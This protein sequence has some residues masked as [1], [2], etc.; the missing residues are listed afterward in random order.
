MT[1]SFDSLSNRTRRYFSDASMRRGE[2]Y[3]EE[4][5]V[6]LQRV[7]PDGVKA[8]V[9]GSGDASYEL[10][11]RWDRVD[12]G[13]LGVHCTCPFFQRETE[14][15]KHLWA[16]IQV[17]D[18]EGLHRLAPGNEPLELLNRSP[19]GGHGG[20]AGRRS[21]YYAPAPAPWHQ[22]LH[23]LQQS[24]AAAN[25]GEPVLRSVYYLINPDQDFAKTGTL[26]LTFFR[27]NVLAGGGYGKL[28]RGHLEAD[29]VPFLEPE[30][31]RL[32]EILFGLATGDWQGVVSGSYGSRTRRRSVAIDP[33]L[34]GTLL[35]LLC[36]TG[37][38]GWLIKTPE[39]G[40][41]P[42]DYD[43]EP[44]WRFEIEGTSDGERLR[45]GG[46]F[47][48]ETLQEDGSLSLERRPASEARIAFASGEVFFGRTVSRLQHTRS[49]FPWLASLRG[50]QD[51]VIPHEDIGS[52]LVSV[53]EIPGTPPL[54]LPEGLEWPTVTL[55][56]E[57][58]LTV[59]LERGRVLGQPF[60]V[61]GDQRLAP[62]S[63]NGS[64]ADPEARRIV[65]RD[66][67]A[68]TGL[69]GDLDPYR[70]D[71]G[72]PFYVASS[73]FSEISE[74]LRARGWSLEAEGRRLRAS[75]SFSA[76]VHSRAQN[77]IDWFEL[78]GEM[79][80]EIQAVQLPALL[81]A[82]GRGEG[83]VQLDDG[84][85]GLL[86][87][88]W[89]ERFAPLS[90]L[91]TGAP[92][93]EALRFE[94]HQALF[95]DALLATQPEVEVDA[96]FRRVRERLRAFGGL[97]PTP[98][99]KTFEGT[100]RPYQEGGVAW[101]EWLG[102]LGLGGCLADDMGLGKT[103]QVLALLEHRRLAGSHGGRPSLLVVP[104]SVVHNWGSEARRFTPGL[105]LVTYHGP[106]RR[107]VL[108]QTLAADGDP[109]ILVTTYATL[110]RDVATLRG[111]HF[112]LVVLDEAQA[113]KNSG[114]QTAKACRLV[115]GDHRLALTGTP[116]ENHLG[117]LW[118]LFE[119][120][121]PG[122]LGSLPAT[123]SIAG[124][125]QLPAESVEILA[126]AIRPL[127][128]RRTKSQV[129]QD[130]PTKTEQTLYC[131]LSE[132]ERGRYEELL[133]HY[134]S[135]LSDKMRTA[136]LNRSKMVVLEALLR[137]RQASCHGGL[138]DPGLRDRSSAKIDV[139]ESRLEEII[140]E[141]DK[142]LV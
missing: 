99:P 132:K 103:I 49:A 78:D 51:L 141:G 108:E 112:D 72:E 16:L 69:R 122:M 67:A 87:A 114:S 60:F 2:R 138:I 129:L 113:I 65:K 101:M 36:A 29:D 91:L 11:I 130:L 119:F 28:Q 88:E 137:L 24:T 100:L 77:A 1:R 43:P 47:T 66:Y 124:K 133:V 19:L 115:Q 7:A 62:D 107:E 104:R 120:L 9:R 97:E 74:A 31:Q 79:L 50:E 56:P 80:F 23:G 21:P 57:P 15:C 142:A 83:F 106:G 75:S 53:S 59:M 12:R 27:R 34:L 54:N 118:S 98:A 96:V 84:S 25:S 61:Y 6:T 92:D 135:L 95:L 18:A 89:I 136:G 32:V 5:R 126:Q 86:P 40:F 14:G 71:A 10:E 48:R 117:E 93:E 20:D 134:R 70:G 131:E 52:F 4:G 116:V 139:L 44:G 81:R 73:D 22:W 42:L 110:R 76:Q 63:T 94:G 26:R 8:A 39:L 58:L 13:L 123:S 37:R 85:V 102:E 55:E 41:E 68:E 127:I 125:A 90:R 35:P 64:W 17:L 46:A 109:S 82:A 45:L 128:L 3:A 121:N 140:E 105:R 33:A 38:F 111:V 30:D